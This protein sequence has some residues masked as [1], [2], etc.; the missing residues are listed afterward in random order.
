MLRTS[1]KQ[2]SQFNTY[3]G[4]PL[5]QGEESVL[6]GLNAISIKEESQREKEVLEVGGE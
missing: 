3:N 1:R 6:K 2:E 5:S 4:G